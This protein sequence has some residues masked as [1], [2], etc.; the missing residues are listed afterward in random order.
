MIY[1]FTDGTITITQTAECM[2]YI[3]L[4]NKLAAGADYDRVE[5]EQV[6]VTVIKGAGETPEML[7]V[8]DKLTGIEY[9]IDVPD[10]E[11][12]SVCVPYFLGM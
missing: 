11:T 2:A 9:T 4:E 12:G 7:F 5:N 6:V 8:V 3:Q 10:H 1:D